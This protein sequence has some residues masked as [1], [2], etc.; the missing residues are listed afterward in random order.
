VTTGAGKA[1]KSAIFSSWTGKAGKA[2]LFSDRKAGKA[3]IST[4]EIL[5]TSSIVFLGWFKKKFLVPLK[6][7]CH[8]KLF[9]DML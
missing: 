5:K 7:F 9:Y 4:F 3:G 1:E 2:V 8:E 6:G